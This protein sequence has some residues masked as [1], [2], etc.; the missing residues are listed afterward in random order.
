MWSFENTE[1]TTATPAAVWARYAEP[2]TWPEWD[3][4]IEKVTVE[5]PLA[6]GT[7]GTLKPVGG[8]LTRFAYTQVEP[9]VSFTDVTKLPL[10]R[11]TF[12]HRI[13]PTAEGCRFTHQ[14]SI[15][16]PLSWLFA[17]IIGRKIEAGLATAM[18][19]LA[20]MAERSER[21]VC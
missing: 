20:A 14:V 18:R 4:E 8:P 10:A 3:H 9:G 1:T 13:E 15:T 2:T 11:L 16:G 7:R 17:R 6:V 21:A 19:A 5:G 12:R